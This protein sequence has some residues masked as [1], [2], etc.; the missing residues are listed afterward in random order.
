M[1]AAAD[2]AIGRNMRV[3]ITGAALMEKRGLPRERIDILSEGGTAE[4][5]PMSADRSCWIELFMP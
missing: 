4:Y 2:L 5:E 1:N 3:R